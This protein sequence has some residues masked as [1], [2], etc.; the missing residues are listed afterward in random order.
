MMS[1][2][3]Y[4]EQ[5]EQKINHLLSEKKYA[6]AYSLC[7][8][9]LLKYPDEKFFF[10]LKKRVEDEI[11]DEN[12]RIIKEKLNELQ[13]LWDGEK[14]EEILKILK[15]LLRLDPTNGKVKSWYKKT[16]NA[17]QEKLSHLTSQF[18]KQQSEKLN[19]L[20]QKDP[21]HL[22]DELFYIERNNAKNIE[23][24]R[25][26]N[27]F[28]DKLITKKISAKQDLLK[29]EK[30]DSINNFIED[31]KR[32]D[33]SNN[34]IKKLQD[35]ILKRKSKSQSSEKI[36]YIYKSEKQL[37]TLMKFKKY[38]KAIKAAQ[39]ILSIDQNNE[40]VQ[41][42]LKKAENKFFKKS[43]ETTIDSIIANLNQ[44]KEQYKKDKSK[45]IKL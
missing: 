31:L 39:E 19:Q 35:E 26:T 37:K 13:S 17:Y 14:Y 32:I 24:L 33:P 15:E 9:F 25:M 7:K 42:I 28:R 3:A 18:T 16:A 45:F 43:R 34:Q 44:L 4:F 21:D 22:L 27:S 38:D 23:V 11:R 41:K 8:E 5:I 10:K 36:S 1:D 6:A 29:S 12:Q 20:L 2:S 30:Y 40:K